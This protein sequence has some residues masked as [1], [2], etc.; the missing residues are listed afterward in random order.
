[1]VGE[2]MGEFSI[3]AAALGNLS[4]FYFYSYVAM[5][6][7]TGLL[8][9]RLG[10]RK[11]LTAGAL[12]AAVGGV[13]FGLAPSLEI[14]LA[15]RLLVGGSVAVAFVGMMKLASR[16]FSARQFATAA[17]VSLLIG[18]TGAVVAGVPLRILVQS[19]GWRPVMVGTGLLTLVVALAIYRFGADDPSERGYASH[20]PPIPEGESDHVSVVASLKAVTHVP[21]TW[22]ILVALAGFCGPMLAFGGLWG[23]PYCVTRFG[24]S[25]QEAAGITSASLLATGLGSPLAG[26]FSDKIARRKLPLAAGI[27]TATAAWLVALLIDS[28]SMG[29]FTVAV[30]VAGF[31]SGSMVIGFAY[32]KESVP[33]RYAGTVGGVINMGAMGGPMLLQPAIGFMLDRNWAGTVE[34][35]VR[36]YDLAAF[37]SSF[38]LIL[39]WMGISCLAILPTTDTCGKQRA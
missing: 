17:G 12:V 23:V 1:M 35:G 38:I 27:V 22:L 20:A 10:P 32:A 8:A 7:P 25:Q 34:G 33:A 36:I 31:A 19:L 24:I 14:A 3:T 21:N 13:C 28:L 11:L 39:F 2:L 5:Q 37:D 16:W 30:V 18:L 6:I 26:W 29:M 9:D 15:G 4:A